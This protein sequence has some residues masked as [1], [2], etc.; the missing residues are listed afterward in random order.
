[1]RSI[2]LGTVSCGASAGS[3][4][5]SRVFMNG[6][7]VGFD[8]AVAAR[9]QQIRWLTGTALYLAAVLQVLWS[10]SAP[11]FE[12]TLD[13]ESWTRKLLLMAVGNGRCAGGGFF[14]TPRAVVDDGIL[15]VTAIE[16]IPISKILRLMPGVMRGKEIRDSAL[17]YIRTREITMR[18][19]RPFMVH[20]D[21]EI[22]GRDVT[23][24]RIGIQEKR[25]KL[26]V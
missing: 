2:D 3:S 20:A 4:L 11:E 25:L 21:G 10:Y 26:A 22:V 15:D 16:E 24:V 7:G 12:V 6:V 5:P 8:A 1:V 23:E 14:L 9:T 13:A 19:D 18:A 17:Q